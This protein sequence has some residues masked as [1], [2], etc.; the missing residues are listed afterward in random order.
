MLDA[1]ND[2]ELIVADP[3]KKKNELVKRY[4]SERLLTTKRGRLV[5]RNEIGLISV[6]NEVA[7][8]TEMS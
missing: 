3:L 5:N 4:D 7:C 8:G 6:A 1:L 2:R